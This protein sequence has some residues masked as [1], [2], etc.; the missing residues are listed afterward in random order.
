M[1]CQIQLVSIFY[2]IFCID[3]CEQVLL[4][5]NYSVTLVKDG[6]AAFF[7]IETRAME[8]YSGRERLGKWEFVA[9]KQNGG[10]LVEN[11]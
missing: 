9:K 11:H 3:I 1:C 6:K 4:K 2:R 10:Q 7:S 8:F 5:K